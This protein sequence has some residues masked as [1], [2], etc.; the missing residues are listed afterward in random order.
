MVGSFPAQNMFFALSQGFVRSSHGFLHTP[1]Q[2]AVV[3]LES[4]LE[5]FI[6]AR[7]MRA[8]ELQT[9]LGSST[10]GLPFESFE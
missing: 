3:G 10:V 7:H 4:G 9:A 6:S 2:V 1:L 8:S 5:G